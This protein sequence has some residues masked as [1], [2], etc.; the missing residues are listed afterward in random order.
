MA[1]KKI[2]GITVVI[3]GDTT[4]LDKAL[5]GTNKTISTTTSRL[6]DLNKQLKLDPTNIELL[7]QKQ[8]RLAQNAEAT[9]EKYETLKH[10]LETSTVSNVLFEKW[11]KAEA[12]FQ[13]Q[14]TKT[15]NEIKTLE[16]EAKRL[17]DLGF[18]PDS[19]PML[20]VQQKMEGAREEA[21][22][23]KKA[24]AD[25]FDELGRPINVEGWD[26][27]QLEASKAKIA[28]ESARKEYERFSPVLAKFGGVAQEVSDKAGKVADA[29]KGLSLAA[30]GALTA[31]GGLA[32]KAG[33]SA[34]DLN[35]LSKQTGFSTQTLQEW[36][37]ASDLVDVSV[38]DIVGAAR[39]LKQNMESTSTDV[40]EA[41]AKLG[42][43]FRDADGFRD[44]EYVFNDVLMAMSEIPNET[45][46]DIVAMTLFGRSADQLA[47]IIDDGGE[48]F[49]R[50]GKEAQEAGLILS[51]DALDSANA[52]NDQLDELKAKASGSFLKMGTTL[53]DTLLPALEN[54]VD[55]IAPPL[56]WI[57]KLDRNT[58]QFV[59]TILA[60]VAAISP[61]A[62]AI[63]KAAASVKLLT[64][65]FSLLSKGISAVW[66]L[67]SA[68]PMLAAILLIVAAL[69][70]LILNW[71]KVKETVQNV[72]NAVVGYIEKGI[73]AVQ[74]FFAA[75]NSSGGSKGGGNIPAGGGLPLPASLSLDNYPHFATGGVFAPNNPMLGVL[76][77]NKSEYEV[78]AP[79]S[80]IEDSV[81]SAMSRAG[82]GS[83][84]IIRVNIQYTGNLAQL[85]RIL[86][87]LITVETARLG[88]SL[89]PR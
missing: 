69:A 41:W 27:L 16:K 60:L 62:G 39:K 71:D 58:L 38:D 72:M 80:V 23:L 43:S 10:T 81:L 79:E 57:S 77:D 44:V 74:R 83:G 64:D 3:G 82:F 68:N 14:I 59:V 7:D 9:N 1:E 65:G 86:Q 53:A 37:Y 24:M 8:R 84:Q 19:A 78:A 42:V 28:S 85:G 70:A 87:P 45:E 47:G 22:R 61:V 34:D 50:L 17:E 6:K 54:L 89:A 56:D 35:T 5:Q 12:S 32:V 49:R 55:L 33:L 52:F 25:T 11:K 88:P 46:R 51:Q 48:A 31:L 36:Q 21:E 40:A 66:G 76:G 26:N 13:G 63:S 2:R 73:S 30:G 29:T 75:L 18:A 20:E 67:F 4:K 15:V